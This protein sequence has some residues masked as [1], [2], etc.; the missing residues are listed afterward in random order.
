MYEIR[1]MEDVSNILTQYG[2]KAK[3]S[4]TEKTTNKCLCIREF[5][6]DEN[7]IPNLSCCIIEQL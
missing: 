7:T 4:K 3:R 2:M 5:V 6:L 1:S